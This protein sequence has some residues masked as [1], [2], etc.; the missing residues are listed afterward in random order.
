L[1]VKQ[2]KHYNNYSDSSSSQ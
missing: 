2:M 1:V